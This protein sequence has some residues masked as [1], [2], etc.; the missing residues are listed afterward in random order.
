M[1]CTC[2]A[3]EAPA[4]WQSPTS[5]ALEPERLNCLQAEKL[6]AEVWGQFA[7]A[8]EDDAIAGLRS[9][10]ALQQLKSGAPPLNDSQLMHLGFT[11]W[12]S[13]YQSVGNAS[14]QVST[15]SIV[16]LCLLI[17]TCYLAHHV[18][19]CE[20]LYHACVCWYLFASFVDNVMQS[21]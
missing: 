2:R 16:K 9:E 15:V 19:G 12:E 13:I 11:Y 6:F 8:V 4:A 14:Y 17:E 18:R 3:L 20:V 21:P 5:S 10:S 7:E 1:Q